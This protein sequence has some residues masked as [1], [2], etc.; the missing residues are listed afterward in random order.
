MGREVIEV[1]LYFVCSVFSIHMDR[2]FLNCTVSG[3]RIHS[4][5]DWMHLIN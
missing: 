4:L 2:M 5:V 3:I 1:K